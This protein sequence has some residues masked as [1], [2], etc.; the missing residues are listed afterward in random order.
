M[1]YDILL[2]YRNAFE[3]SGNERVFVFVHVLYVWVFLPGYNVP[4]PNQ[5]TCDRDNQKQEKR[6]L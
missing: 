5:Q 1:L 6:E 3:V 2:N 4:S